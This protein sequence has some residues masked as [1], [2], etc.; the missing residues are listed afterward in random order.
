[1]PMSTTDTS[2]VAWKRTGVIGTEPFGT[3]IEGACAAT[4]LGGV[5]R[6]SA[7]TDI[8]PLTS[9]AH[10]GLGTAK[11]NKTPAMPKSVARR[12]LP[13]G[14]LPKTHRAGDAPARG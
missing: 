14:D 13:I 2:S 9:P 12:T 6:K 10:A 3:R 4:G 7:A 1:M 11:L 8:V 5:G